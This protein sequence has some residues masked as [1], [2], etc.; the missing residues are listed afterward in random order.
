MTCKNPQVLRG[1]CGTPIY[2]PCLTPQGN[3]KGGSARYGEHS[4]YLK[5]TSFK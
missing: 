2:L 5:T 1:S 4:S 3:F